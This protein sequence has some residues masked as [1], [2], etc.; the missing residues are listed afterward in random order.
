MKSPRDSNRL[1]GDLAAPPTPLFIWS[2]AALVFLWHLTLWILISNRQSI[3]LTPIF[4]HLDASWY[5]NIA[6]TGY[7]SLKAFAFYPAYPALLSMFVETLSNWIHPNIAGSI[8]ST[9]LFGAF[10]WVLCRLLH[11]HSN[12]FPSTRL[13]WLLFI[14][15]P[16][17]YVFHTVHTES[18][19]IVLFA[20]ALYFFAERKYFAAA[21]FAGLTAL[22][23]N[24]GVILAACLGAAPLYTIGFNGKPAPEAFGKRLSRFL[25]FACVSGGIWSFYPYYQ[26]KH[27]GDPLL[28][29]KAQSY[30]TAEISPMTYLRTFWFGNPWQNTGIG[31]IIHHGIFIALSMSILWFWKSTKN[32]PLTWFLVLFMIIR[33]LQGELVSTLRF[34]TV[35]FPLLFFVGDGLAILK[36]RWQY[37]LILAFLILNW[38]MTRAY[39]LQRWAY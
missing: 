29:L 37:L 32:A 11:R 30:W 15:F 24:E 6:R 13:G 18:L 26:N 35:L 2:S 8:F 31:S 25:V 28:F 39:G 4:G 34:E 14:V 1:R 22:T 19:F 17:T 10:L 5:I 3:D 7:F 9:I 21:V 36:R 38:Q 12:Y 27:L 16:C 33:P 23:R 20:L